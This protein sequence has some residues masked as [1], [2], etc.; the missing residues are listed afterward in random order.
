MTLNDS[1]SDAD[2]VAP[3]ESDSDTDSVSSERDDLVQIHF[4]TMGEVIKTCIKHETR[5]ILIVAAGGRGKTTAARKFMLLWGESKYLP[6]CYMAL[7]LDMKQ[8]D[9][10][11]DSCDKLNR[12]CGCTSAIFFR[13]SHKAEYTTGYI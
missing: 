3:L 4:A 7:R 6:D 5:L 9:F 11:K 8:V 10:S 2:T 13:V 12:N 1:D